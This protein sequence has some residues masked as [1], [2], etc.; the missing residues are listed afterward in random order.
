MNCRWVSAA[1][2]ESVCV[3]VCVTR[4]WC[5]KQCVGGRKKIPPLMF[6]KL[7]LHFLWIHRQR[8]THVLGVYTHDK[9][10]SGANIGY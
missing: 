1:A 7:L 6:C 8:M 3:F 5:E 4:E 9:I 10:S 2:V